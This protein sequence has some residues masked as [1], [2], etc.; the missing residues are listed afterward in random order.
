[1]TPPPPSAPS[2]ASRSSCLPRVIPVPPRTPLSISSKKPLLISPATPPLIHLLLLLL[3]PLLFLPLLP[4]LFLLL[5][6][7]LLPLLLLSQLLLLLLGTPWPRLMAMRSGRCAPT[8]AMCI[9]TSVRW[10]GARSGARAR[11]AGERSR[12]QRSRT[13]H[14]LCPAQ[15]CTTA[16]GASSPWVSLRQLI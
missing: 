1:L 3:L 8:A 15:T 16:R 9:N 11:V 4:L 5:F 10:W 6:L 12:P 14:L 2:T 13:R 7:F